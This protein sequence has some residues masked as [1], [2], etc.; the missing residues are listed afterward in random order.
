[1]NTVKIKLLDEEFFKEF[2]L[3]QYE[4][5][6]AAG[7]DLRACIEDQILVM[8]NERV[9][10]KTGFAVDMNDPNLGMLLLPRSGLG[11]KQGL[12]LG[13]LVG[14]VDSD[15]H[16]EVLISAWATKD[17]VRITRG[18]RLAQAVFVPIVRVGFDVVEE[19]DRSV[20]RVGGFG[21][22]GTH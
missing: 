4:T 17:A 21:H 14:L 2:G 6:E 8:E 22:T 12:V 1:M 20:A 18:M 11:H 5:P 15:Y 13:N 19:F 9:L 10:I 3:P 16:Q 7:L